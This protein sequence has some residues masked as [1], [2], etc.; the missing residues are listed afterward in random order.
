M[1]TPINEL[2]SK[3]NDIKRNAAIEQFSKE[4]PKTFGPFN[5]YSVEEWN[6]SYYAYFSCPDLPKI[7]IRMFLPHKHN[8]LIIVIYKNKNE[9]A[10]D[11]IHNREDFE[12]VQDKWKKY[13]T[14][15]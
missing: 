1:L 4:L 12:R 9:L 2:H 5:F 7:T 13:W 15:D 10:A 14:I 3:I 11:Q 8:G 6:D